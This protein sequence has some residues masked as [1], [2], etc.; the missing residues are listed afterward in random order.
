[1]TSNYGALVRCLWCLSPVHR[2]DVCGLAEVFEQVHRKNAPGRPP[3]PVVF[4][5]GHST[6]VPHLRQTLLS[7]RK[8]RIAYL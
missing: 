6:D 4:T 1:M 2:R 3:R 7:R 8:S 5:L